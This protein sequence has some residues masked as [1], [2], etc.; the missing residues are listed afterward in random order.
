MSTKKA[1]KRI[2]VV[3]IAFVMMVSSVFTSIP[4]VGVAHAAEGTWIYVDGSD[5]NNGSA[6]SAVK[7]W[8]RARDLLGTNAGGIYVAGT[9]EASGHINTL[10][11]DKQSVKR[12]DGFTGVMFEVP[13]GATATF[14]SIDVDGEDKRIDGAVIKSNNSSTL[15][16]LKGATFHNIGYIED[17]SVNEDATGVGMGKP[18]NTIGGVVCLL[19]NN[20][21]ILVDGAEFSNNKGKGIFFAPIAGWY[22][23]PS[24]VKLTMKSG[25]VINNDGFFYHNECQ[26][27]PNHVFIYNALIRNNDASNIGSRYSAYK[28]RTGAVYVC[29]YGSMELRN[30]EGAAIFDNKNHDIIYI[31]NPGAEKQINFADQSTMLG[32]GNPNWSHGEVDDSFFNQTDNEWR[33]QHYDVYDSNPSDAAKAAAESKATSVSSSSESFLVISV[34]SFCLSRKQK[35]NY[36]F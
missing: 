17:S 31:E 28:N 4:F 14:Y 11:P 27:K 18:T 20:V 35:H 13:G 29:I 2:V 6:G 25:R 15:S 8:E 32:D 26:E 10:A 24:D 5:S 19:D 22:G 3:L 34:A 9:V 12:A 23:G 30:M 1:M 36:R 33:Y 21:S 7:S 16:F